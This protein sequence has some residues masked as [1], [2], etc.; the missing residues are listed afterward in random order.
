VHINF[1]RTFQRDSDHSFSNILFYLPWDSHCVRSRFLC[2]AESRSLVVSLPNH[3]F[4]SFNFKCFLLHNAHQV[5][6]LPSI[7]LW[8]VTLHLW[9]TSK[10]H[11]DSPSLLRSQGGEDNIPWCCVGGLCIHHEKCWFSHCV[12]ANPCSSTSHLL[13]LM[14]IGW[15]FVFSWW[16]SHIGR[17]HHYWS[18]SSWLGFACNIVSVGDCDDGNKGRILLKSRPC[19]LI[20]PSGH[21][22][23]LVF[24]PTSQQFFSSIC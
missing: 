10:P 8:V 13:N 14:P 9:P 5:R 2:K 12:Q 16:H 4:S 22:G 24:T 19:E 6:P 11:G 3:P 17:C 7:G 21:W 23:I 15:H 18:H 1:R 20:S